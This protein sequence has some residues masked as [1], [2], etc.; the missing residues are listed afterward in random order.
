MGFKVVAKVRTF[1][2]DELWRSGKLFR[3]NGAANSFV[4]ILVVFPMPTQKEMGNI[5][6]VGPQL[7]GHTLRFQLLNLEILTVSKFMVNPIGKNRSVNL[8]N[9]SVQLLQN[10]H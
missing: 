1:V 8:A 4:N 2:G 10:R 9:S 3:R 7:D 6:S 5:G